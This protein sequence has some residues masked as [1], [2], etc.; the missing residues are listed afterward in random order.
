MAIQLETEARVVSTGNNEVDKKLGG[1]I[2]VGSLVLVEGQSDSGKSVISQHFAHGALKG[3]LATVYYTTENTVKSLISQMNSLDLDVTDYF[4][5]DRL[6]VYPVLCNEDTDSAEAFQLLL[7]HFRILPVTTKLIIVDSL[8]GM[9]THG[10]ER[11]VIDFF[12]ACKQLCDYGKTI[13]CVV[14]SHAF[15]EK[16]LIRIRSL[17]DAHLTLRMEQVGDRL[18][19]VLEVGKVRNA[20]QSTGNVISFDV[21]PGMGMRLIPSSRAKA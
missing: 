13:M 7:A 8:T 3:K 20:D 5:C 1:G 2:P 10:D 11:S 16:M 6:R 21:E 12:S 15:D 18:V 4:L 17:C 19:K 9:V 14:H